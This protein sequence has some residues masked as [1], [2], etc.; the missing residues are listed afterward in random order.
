[1]I[2]RKLYIGGSDAAPIL[3]LSRWT[4][5]YQTYLKKRGEWEPEITPERQELFDMGNIM[6]P[7]IREKLFPRWW[8]KTQGQ[9]LMSVSYD[10]ENM[11]CQ[12]PDEGGPIIGGNLD[13]II[14][15]YDDKSII[16]EYAVLECKT[17]D[18]YTAIKWGDVQTDYV[19][20]EYACQCQHY[21]MI[22]GAKKCYLAVLIGGNDFRVYVL[23]ADQEFHEILKAEYLRFWHEV[24][25]GNPPESKTLDDCRLKYPQDDSLDITADDKISSYIARI[26]QAKES[27]KTI[28]NE[29]DNLEIAVKEYMGEAVELVDKTGKKLV[30]WKTQETT[31]VDTTKLKTDF[32]EVYKAVCKVSSSRVFRT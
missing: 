27:I 31:R 14:R 8:A 11:W 30:S 15:E 16:T 9:K 32:P 6:E 3:G 10:P 23:K 7:V 12:L 1:L 24:K 25:S 5:R 19:P 20:P 18:K 28:Q 29:S 26:R 13:G 17:A 21:M 4:T 22:S 2:D